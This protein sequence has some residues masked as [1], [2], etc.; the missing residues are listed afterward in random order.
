MTMYKNVNLVEIL[1]DCPQ[2]TK[3]YSIVFG[4]VS[5]YRVIKGS[6]YPINVITSNGVIEGVD[7]EGKL[8]SKY[9]GECTLF[10]SKEQR[11]WYEFDSKLHVDNDIKDNNSF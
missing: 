1:K 6:K 3:L 11:D 2:G 10:P 7:S 5:L 8:F 9:D 4:Y